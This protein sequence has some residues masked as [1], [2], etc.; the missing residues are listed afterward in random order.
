MVPFQPNMPNRSAKKKKAQIIST[1]SSKHLNYY[2]IH[3]QP[4]KVFQDVQIFGI[5]PLFLYYI[6]PKKSMSYI[7]KIAP[8]LKQ[9]VRVII[10]FRRR[11]WPTT[12]KPFTTLYINIHI[13]GGIGKPQTD[14]YQLVVEEEQD[15]DARFSLCDN[16]YPDLTDYMPY[17]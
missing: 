12:R 17:S 1:Q 7:L 15:I 4:F 3:T 11:I 2:Y 6:T 16:Q 5:L 13:F 8:N 14:F 9:L 10:P